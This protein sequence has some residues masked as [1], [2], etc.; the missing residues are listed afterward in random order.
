MSGHPHRRVY[1]LAVY[2]VSQALSQATAIVRG[3]LVPNLLGPAGYGLIATVNAADRYTP[4]VSAG[5]HYFIVNRLPVIDDPRDR[6]RILD[7]IFTFTLLTSLLSA[8][9]VVAIAIFQLHARGIVVA[10]GIA[11]LALNPLSAGVWRLHASLLRVDEKIPLMMRLTNAQTFVSSALIVGFTW[12]WGIAG[13][14]TAQLLTAVFVL[15]LVRMASPYDFR[16]GWDGAVLRMIL[17]FTIPVFFVAGLLAT[18]VDTMEVFVLAHGVGVAAVGMYAWGTAL[19]AILLM[20]TN[21]LTTVYS[22]PVVKAVH[23]DGVTGRTDGVRLFVRLLLANCLVFVGLAVMAYV[24]LPVAVRVLFPG[25]QAGIEAA[26]LLVVS[27][28]YE[29]ISVLG[30]FVLTAQKRFNV[31]LVGLAVLVIVLL[32][33]LWWLAPRGIVWI[34]ALAILRRLGKAHFVVHIGLRRAFDRGAAYWLF[35]IGIYLLGLL[36][37]IAGWCIDLTHLEVRRDNIVE[38]LPQIA[39]TF[40][41][42]GLVILGTLYGLHRRFRVL[43]ALWQS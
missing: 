18:T 15:V 35:C 23:E 31:Y 34:A 12:Q 26:R 11:T 27:V 24:F 17:A 42:L 32:P 22:S 6:A 7:T 3:L 13:T 29:N 37:L 40:G 36:P 19:A 5:S 30:L 1:D 43:E 9:A 10:Y 16:I 21:G 4:Y 39:T 41:V 8:A 28:Y 38:F 14:F 25:F 2:L 20:W 33:L